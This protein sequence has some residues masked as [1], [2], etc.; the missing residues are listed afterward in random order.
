MS[1]KPLKKKKAVIDSAGLLP[2][3][4]TLDRLPLSHRD[5]EQL[6][7]LTRADIAICSLPRDFFPSFVRLCKSRHRVLS[8]LGQMKISASLFGNMSP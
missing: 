8:Y 4:T 3:Y 5:T 6:K 7:D 2:G 1:I